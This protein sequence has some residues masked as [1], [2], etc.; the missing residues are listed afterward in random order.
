MTLMDDLKVR[1]EEG[2]KTLKETAEGIAFNVE[3]QAKI[4]RKKMEI[5]KL[6]RRLQKVYCEMGEYVH[7]EFAMERPVTPEAPFLGERVAA[8]NQMKM[9]IRELEVEIDEIKKTQPPKR[10]EQES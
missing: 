2:F 8:V 6:Q 10:E 1:A 7:G 5:S 4:A 9:D 3:K